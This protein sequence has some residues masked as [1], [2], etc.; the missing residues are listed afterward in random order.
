MNGARE[1]HQR[2]LDMNLPEPEVKD[3]KKE[4]NVEKIQKANRDGLL[5]ANNS[6]PSSTASLKKDDS[7][8]SKEDSHSF[9]DSEPLSNTF[10]DISDPDTAKK[11]EQESSNYVIGKCDAQTSVE[12][13]LSSL[14]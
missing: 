2:L 4:D 5:D 11:R 1:L 6:S 13:F 8:S 3:K 7:K 14:V 9:K 12:N 10:D